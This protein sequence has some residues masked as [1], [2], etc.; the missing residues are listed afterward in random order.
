MKKLLFLSLLS[1]LSVEAFAGIFGT[2][3]SRIQFKKPAQPIRKTKQS[4]TIRPVQTKTVTPAFSGASITPAIEPEKSAQ[5]TYLQ[6][7][8]QT[9]K[10]FQFT[11]PLFPVYSA[12]LE[13]PVEQEIEPAPSQR[14]IL[15]P[16]QMAQKI[17]SQAEKQAT[18]KKTESV[19]KEYPA[20]EYPMYQELSLIEP[21]LEQEEFVP[22]LSEIEG[23]E[24]AQQRFEQR[25]LTRPQIEQRKI[26]L[27]LAGFD[28]IAQHVLEQLPQEESKEMIP[29]EGYGSQSVAQIAMRIGSLKGLAIPQVQQLIKKL[30]VDMARLSGYNS[31]QDV[32]QL[33]D[34]AILRNLFGTTVERLNALAINAEREQQRPQISEQKYR[35]L[36]E[37]VNFGQSNYIIPVVSPAQII[38]PIPFVAEPIVQ[39]APEPETIIEKNIQEPV[40]K[41][42]EKVEPRVPAQSIEQI[43][44][45][46]EI[47]MPKSQENKEEQ[48]S[49]VK[50][51]AA[52]KEGAT[53]E[54]AREKAL[55]ELKPGTLELQQAIVSGENLPPEEQES[56]IKE[57]AAL[58]EGVFQDVA[59]QQA[60][61]ELKPGTLQLQQAIVAGGNLPPTIKRPRIGDVAGDDENAFKKI[62]KADSQKDAKKAISEKEQIILSPEI[63]AVPEKIVDKKDEMLRIEKDSKLPS[64]EKKQFEGKLPEIKKAYDKIEF[65][66]WSRIQPGRSRIIP[67]SSNR[68]RS[69]DNAPYESTGT[70]PIREFN[71]SFAPGDRYRNSSVTRNS[72]AYPSIPGFF[73]TGERNQLPYGGY[74]IPAT[75]SEKASQT[76][77]QKPLAQPFGYAKEGMPTAPFS[78]YRE[79]DPY[80]GP[81]EEGTKGNVSGKRMQPEEK[82]NYAASHSL[83]S[84]I[85]M[86]IF[87]IAL[88]GATI[89]WREYQKR[90]KPF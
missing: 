18:I 61:I 53:Q 17:K 11:K 9:I 36:T 20:I 2:A 1:L 71:Q 21:E 90:K 58:K 22:A 72:A 37:P 24:I 8:T 16:A 28:T 67:S 84:G 82:K 10:S 43:G 87:F 70:L 60:L 47:S 30:V 44:K 46:L 7:F 69:T 33:P 50:E 29:F 35:A 74:S 76:Q 73:D 80:Q 78:P 13:K 38:P 75:P 48:N 12:P 55:I 52:L 26:E 64:S 40:S 86:L 51:S 88:I 79:I 19:K 49:I 42:V 39:I 45:E 81:M 59:R 83:T 34:D 3:S 5:P 32:I 41:A 54:I 57:S 23:Q 14:T 31:R 85:F 25:A 66:P 62:K 63:S 65:T 15:T 89:I 68:A 4:P 6:R 56:I 77:E 27:I